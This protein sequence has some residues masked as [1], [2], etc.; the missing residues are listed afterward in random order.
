MRLS[1][2][3]KLTKSTFESPRDS[4]SYADQEVYLGSLR[5]IAEAFGLNHVK[6]VLF[7]LD[8]G[9]GHSLQD[10]HAGIRKKVRAELKF[11][12]DEPDDRRVFEAIDACIFK[13][14]AAILA[15][16]LSPGGRDPIITVGTR[17]FLAWAKDN[18]KKLPARNS[19]EF[20]KFRDVFIAKFRADIDAEIA[21]QNRYDDEST[22]LTM[23]DFDDDESEVDAA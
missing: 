13:K 2:L 6:S 20:A 1:H 9:W 8:S 4:D 7:L 10:S 21:E 12:A 22:E 5:V 11:D 14:R 3:C 18:K 19:A 23:D 17:M 16:K 15:G